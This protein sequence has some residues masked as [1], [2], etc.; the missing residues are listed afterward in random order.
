MEKNEYKSPHGWLII[1]LIVLSLGVFLMA[2]VRTTNDYQST[3]PVLFEPKKTTTTTTTTCPGS[4]APFS[5]V[6]ARNGD[7]MSGND[8][9]DV[10]QEILKEHFASMPLKKQVSLDLQKLKVNEISVGKNFFIYDTSMTTTPDYVTIKILMEAPELKVSFKDQPIYNE[11]YPS[12][13]PYI[14]TLELIYILEFNKMT[15]QPKTTMKLSSLKISMTPWDANLNKK[16]F[17]QIKNSPLHKLQLPSPLNIQ[18]SELY[19][20]LLKSDIF[21][22]IKVKNG[23][24]SLEP[25]STKNLHN[26]P[27]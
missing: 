26:T 27:I 16:S 5:Y 4:T 3:T 6:L 9:K 1:T 18:K 20:F 8:K 15:L 12:L 21:N 22:T 13:N 2:M 17:E 24:I 11:Y 10:V 7:V 23:L 14:H 25:I 19:D